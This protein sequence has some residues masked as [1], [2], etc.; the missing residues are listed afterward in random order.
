VFLDDILSKA[1]LNRRDAPSHCL[2]FCMFC[3]ELQEKGLIRILR[4][5][6]HVL[7]F[8]VVPLSNIQNLKSER[9]LI[10]ALSYVGFYSF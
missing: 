4:I 6:D 5:F 2:C 8:A 3:D 9:N 7:K 10:Y 1:K